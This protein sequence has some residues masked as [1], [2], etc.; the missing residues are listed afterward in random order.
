VGELAAFR[1][2]KSDTDGEVI[3]AEA[4]QVANQLV[5]R[6]PSVGS[7]LFQTS[8][9]VSK[10]TMSPKILSRFAALLPVLRIDERLFVDIEFNRE[11]VDFKHIRMNGEQTWP[12]PPLPRWGVKPAQPNLASARWTA[13]CERHFLPCI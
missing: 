11:G 7:G 4:S 9:S 12:R 1:L 13:L 8:P 3:F 6:A 10:V 5:E 2:T